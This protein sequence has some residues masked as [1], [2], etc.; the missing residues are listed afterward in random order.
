MSQFKKEPLSK[1]QASQAAQD[2]SSILD[3]I[4]WSFSQFEKTDLFYGHGTDNAWDESV[5]LVLQSLELPYDFPERLWSSK[6]TADEKKLITE[7]VLKRVNS[8]TPLAYLT[9]KAFFCGTEYYVDERVLVPRSPIAE[10]IE[11]HFQPW[12]N[13]D[14][15]SHILDLCTGSGC[16]AIACGQA[17]PDALIDGGDISSDCIEVAELNRERL[18]QDNVAFFQSDLFN[19]LAKKQYDIIVSNPPYVDEEDFD[20]IP[21]E[22]LSEPKLGLVSGVDGLDITRKILAQASEFLSD[23]GVL[24]VEVGNSAAALEALYPHLA[25]TWLEFERGG[26]GVFLLTKAQLQAADLS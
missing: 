19:S 23:N 6:L 12:V 21:A 13:P 1:S 4:R 22:F 2:L 15:V 16:I 5:A 25:F 9:N 18:Q 17:F 3:C 20:E 7:R 10:L 26:L 8:K 24:I 14:Q 11:N